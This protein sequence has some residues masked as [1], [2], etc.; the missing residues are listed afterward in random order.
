MLTLLRALLLRLF[1]HLLHNLLL[2]DQECAYDA[3]LDAVGAPRATVGT[4]NG[5][6]WAGDLCVLAR[7]EGGDLLVSMLVVVC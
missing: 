2:L 1:E 7:S 6:L 4:L 5:L 3:V